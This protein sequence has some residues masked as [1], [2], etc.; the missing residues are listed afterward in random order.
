[1]VGALAEENYFDL[2]QQKHPQKKGNNLYLKEN[3]NQN[4]KEGEY[5]HKKL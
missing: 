5:T 3:K 2:S 4:L 1:M